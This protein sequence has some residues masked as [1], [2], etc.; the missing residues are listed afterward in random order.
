MKKIMLVFSGIIS[1]AVIFLLTAYL[2]LAI[3]YKNGFSYNTWINGVYCTGKSVESINEELR[4][5]FE[6]R[7]IKINNPDGSIEY[8]LPDEINYRID[9]T[10]YLNE[11]LDKQNP[12]LWIVNLK[13]DWHRDISAKPVF[14]YDENALNEKINSL[15]FVRNNTALQ[16]SIVEIRKD[17]NGFFLYDNHNAY[18][19]IYKVKESINTALYSEE[20]VFFN[21]DYLI[22][23]VYTDNE[24]NILK[25]WDS[26]KEYL[27]PKLTYDMG[28]EQILIDS[29]ILS[30]FIE[31]DSSGNILRDENNKP[32][33]NEQKMVSF[34]DDLCSK[35]DTYDKDRIFTTSKGET[36]VITNV[37]YGTLLNHEKE[38]KYF[39]EAI[40]AGISETHTP[41]YIRT[42]YVRGLDDIGLTYIEVDMGEQVLYYYED[43]VL[44]LKTDIVSGKPS[45]P[46]PQMICSIYYKKEKA[47]LRG[48][49]YA[50]P[51]DY[52]MAVYKGIGLHDSNWQ[53]KY[54]GDWYLSHGSH[55]CINMKINAVSYVYE[56]AE[57]GTPVILYY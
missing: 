35:Y 45:T 27:T 28:A 47:I 56:T 19:D 36:K 48:P 31:T 3:Y 51:V 18:V 30:S 14:S 23:P 50:S 7:S 5:K 54:G 44:S 55:G 42:G 39:T 8:I 49:G 40:K 33:L 32:L 37:Y 29:K 26:L 25:E 6:T 9:F 4:T 13:G 16:N 57:V 34:I 38:I 24:K 20:P 43:G 1:G 2:L 46:T 11:I 22:Q 15:S 53:R 21:D 41:E 52:W 12:Y 17:E 10:D